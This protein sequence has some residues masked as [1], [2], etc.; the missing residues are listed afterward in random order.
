MRGSGRLSVDNHDLHAGLLEWIETGIVPV[1]LVLAHQSILGSLLEK[2]NYV[3]YPVELKQDMR[4]FATEQFLRYSHNYDPAKARSKTPAFTF[5]AWNAECAFKRVLHKHYRQKNLLESLAEARD[6]WGM[7][8][9]RTAIPAQ[10]A[11]ANDA[12]DRWTLSDESKVEPRGNVKRGRGRPK[13][14]TAGGG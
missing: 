11:K 8:A 13:S 1:E 4:S 7:D 2:S 3:G 10:K 12:P 6:E 14:V 9:Y 5:L